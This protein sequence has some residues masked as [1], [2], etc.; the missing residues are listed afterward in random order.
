M[1]SEI[2]CYGSTENTK[3]I[4]AI[5][6]NQS[7]LGEEI[8]TRLREEEATQGLG[9][10]SSFSSFEYADNQSTSHE[11]MIGG[12]IFAEC[13]SNACLPL[14]TPYVSRS[15]LCGM[16]D[17][18]IILT[19]WNPVVGIVTSQ[20]KLHIFSLP[21]DTDIQCPTVTAYSNLVYS[22]PLLFEQDILRLFQKVEGKEGLFVAS[23]KDFSQLVNNIGFNSLEDS[24]LE[25]LKR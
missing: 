17:A 4:P 8:S 3:Q 5:L 7:T 20:R 21:M 9:T 19:S 16:E 18:G 6:N 1:I 24:S 2:N 14:Y 11:S 15:F 25:D 22:D 10:L 23:N 12:G 13:M